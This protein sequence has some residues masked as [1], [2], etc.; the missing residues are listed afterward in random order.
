M[1]QI[2]APKNLFLKTHVSIVSGNVSVLDRQQATWTNVTVGC[3]ELITKDPIDNKSALLQ[4][5]MAW[6]QRDAELL[7][8]SMLTYW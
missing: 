8:E 7:S 1:F 2:N 5:I 4:V 6:Y 3:K